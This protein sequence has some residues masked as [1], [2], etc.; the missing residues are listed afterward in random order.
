MD[1]L[2]DMKLFLEDIKRIGFSGVHNF[3]TV[4][5]FEGDFRKTLEG[6]GLGYQHEINMLNWA[7]SP[8]CSLLGMPLMRA[9]PNC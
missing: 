1:V 2:R 5:W 3:P 7:R 9:M 8:T 4:A 6:T